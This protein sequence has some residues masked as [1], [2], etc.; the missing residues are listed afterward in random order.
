MRAPSPD[1]DSLGAGVLG[2]RLGALGHGVFSQ[3]A[4]KQQ[5]YRRLDLSGSNGRALVVMR[6]ARR[7]AGNALEDVV[8]ERIHDAHSL[9]RDA[10]VR[11]YL[12]QHLIHVNRI[13]L[14]A[15]ALAFLAILLLHFRDSLFRT[16]FW[17][18]SRFCWI[19]HFCRKTHLY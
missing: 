14:L 4:G 1:K 13:A 2:D 7:F 8:D 17:S 10:G 18:R 5:A 9:G 3:L 12:F 6:Q 19:R 11:V 15:A 16:F